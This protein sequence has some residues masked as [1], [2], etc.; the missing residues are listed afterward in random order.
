MVMNN[1]SVKNL[2]NWFGQFL[3]VDLLVIGQI[4]SGVPLKQYAV[5]TAAAENQWGKHSELEGE[6][7]RYAMDKE[8]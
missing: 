3:H 4:G 8:L 7:C 1:P 5:E 2:S 6:G